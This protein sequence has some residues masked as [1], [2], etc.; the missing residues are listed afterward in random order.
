MPF[1]VRLLVNAVA[2][3]A[4][5]RVVPGVTYSGGWMPML[6]VALVFGVVNAFVRPVAKVLTF[7]V[8]ILTLGLF[9][10]VINGLMLWLTGTLS[11]VLDLGFHVRGF[12]PAF[13]G[14]LVVS[15]V[16]GLLSLVIT[17]KDAA[18]RSR[19]FR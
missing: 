10:L 17:D 2:L 13:W 18:Y 12:R 4:A 5:T 3:W 6:G 15:I 19:T 14:G 11:D 8:V 16:S 9:L 7:P 1:F